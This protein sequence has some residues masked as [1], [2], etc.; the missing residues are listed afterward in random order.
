MSNLREI[1]QKVELHDSV[2]ESISIKGDGT[3]ELFIDFDDVWNKKLESNV[4]GIVFDSVYEISDFKIDRF[5][6]IGSVEV[7]DVQGYSKE[8]VTHDQ[9]EP[10]TVTMIAIEFVAGGSLNI[11]CSGSA[12][13]IKCQ[14]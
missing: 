1:F 7:E 11:I 6:V 2:L 4:R 8:F 3:V 9:N 13:L 12:Q 5:N 10:D 14:A